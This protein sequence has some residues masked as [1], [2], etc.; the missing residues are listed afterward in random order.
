MG[1]F[2]FCGRGTKVFAVLLL[3][4]LVASDVHAQ[5]VG[6]L[7]GPV[8]L[9]ENYDRIKIADSNVNG[10]HVK[11][12][13]FVGD[14]LDL[15]D[16]TFMPSREG[17]QR[18]SDIVFLAREIKIGPAT[19]FLMDGVYSPGSAE[20]TRAG[21]VY[22]A[23]ETI[24]VSGVRTDGNG[25]TAPFSIQRDG[26]RVNPFGA[27]LFDGQRGNVHVFTNRVE[28]SP[29]Y[30]DALLKDISGGATSNTPV[31]APILRAIARSFSSMNPVQAVASGS[32]SI[33][34]SELT[35]S[36]QAWLRS[37]PEFALVARALQ[38]EVSKFDTVKPFHE[39]L[40]ALPGKEVATW[41]VKS[42]QA[43]TGIAK[44]HLLNREYG[45]AATTV[46]QLEESRLFGS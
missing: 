39:L 18:T 23:A 42:L 30:I 40:S 11:T 22:I 46:E 1:G 20:N 27:T 24:V 38:L 6:A 31:P 2:M 14:R 43:G 12:V 4:F 17:Y 7:E 33:M 25:L 3:G 41:F 44:S 36:Y 21:D 19:S 26:A 45:I 13:M 8:R 9:V 29:G 35:G 37:E 5:T 28:Y 34:W 32:S 10:R 16:Q 15:S